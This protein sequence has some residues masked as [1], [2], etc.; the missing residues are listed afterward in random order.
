MTGS[1]SLDGPNQ[2]QQGQCLADITAMRMSL[3]C[4]AACPALLTEAVMRD[5]SRPP[6]ILEVRP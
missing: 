5:L 3:N 2:Q 1:L 4:A 6:L